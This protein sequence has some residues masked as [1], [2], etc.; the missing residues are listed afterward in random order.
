MA[1]AD[2]SRGT[3]KSETSW[4][5]A[6][7]SAWVAQQTVDYAAGKL[8]RVPGKLFADF[9]FRYRNEVTSR[10]DGARWELLRAALLGEPLAGGVQRAPDPL[11]QVRLLDLGPEH[12]LPGEIG[13]C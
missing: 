7:A 12:F 4:T 13:D 11:V 8:G 9:I 6:E 3:D 2:T 1:L 5:K 10:K